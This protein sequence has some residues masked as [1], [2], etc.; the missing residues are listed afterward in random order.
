VIVVASACDCY[1]RVP[2]EWNGTLGKWMK[3]L[4]FS[5]A[6]ACTGAVAAS[7]DSDETRIEQLIHRPVA[8]AKP[9]VKSAKSAA[10]KANDAATWL[11]HRVR[12]E[13]IDHGLYL[14]TLQT[15]NSEAIT[16]LVELPK[17]TL[18]YTLPRTAV[19]RMQSAEQVP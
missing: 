17:R 19:T 11:G 3:L 6:L 15:L 14:G 4:I 7:A 10:A 18:T 1:S 8:V 13:T 16:L 5:L 12:V 2:F 9:L